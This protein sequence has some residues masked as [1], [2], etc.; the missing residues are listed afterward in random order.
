MRASA[1]SLSSANPAALLSSR[2][3]SY[4]KRPWTA[5]SPC[6][7]AKELVPVH[8]RKVFYFLTSQP[9]GELPQNSD[10]ILP[11]ILA[12]LK[13]LTPSISDPSVDEDAEI[14]HFERS[15]MSPSPE[16]DLFSPEL[17]DDLPVPPTPGSSFPGTESIPL[18]PT[19]EVRR[20][21]QR[22][23][24][25]SLEADEKGFTETASAVRAIRIAQ[26]SQ[27]QSPVDET[28]SFEEPEKKPQTDNEARLELFGRTH[29]GL[30]VEQKA[31]L[32]SSP[33]IQP[34]PSAHN[35]VDDVDI[36][37]SDSAWVIKSPEMVD[38]DE[39]DEMF[40]EYC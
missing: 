12:D 30:T 14:E 34:K 3:T 25:P 24:S 5:L 22:A 4:M 37:M 29:G 11:P 10:D 35:A 36:G 6:P 15:R 38:I 33:M 39:L 31:T 9:R 13:R 23:P 27:P 2:L 8:P 18:E 19:Q 40:A 1:N 21:L 16:V 28:M 26:A 20:G 32:A 17:G 7:I